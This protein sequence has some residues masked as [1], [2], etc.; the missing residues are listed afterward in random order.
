MPRE[1]DGHVARTYRVDHRLDA[2]FK[3]R[4]H[5]MGVSMERAV[6]ALMYALTHEGLFSAEQWM[7]LLDRVTSYVESDRD[8]PVEA[9][10]WLPP[11]TRKEIEG[12]VARLQDMTGNFP[13]YDPNAPKR[14]AETIR[15]GRKR[16]GQ[17]A[18]KA[19]S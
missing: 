8:V 1:K 16:V 14:V 12:L 18:R 7:G 2:A 17:A 15:R 11:V 19:R 5:R 6:N 3:E 13:E 9:G 4:C 10:P